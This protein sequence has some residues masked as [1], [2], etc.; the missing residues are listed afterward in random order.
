MYK[1]IYSPTEE[2]AVNSRSSTYNEEEY[3]D[4]AIEF[5]KSLN[6]TQQGHAFTEE[7]C[8]AELEG[9]KDDDVKLVGYTVLTP[10]TTSDTVF[11]TYLGKTYYYRLSSISTHERGRDGEPIRSQPEDVILDWTLGILNVVMALPKLGNPAIAIPYAG[12]CNFLGHENGID[13][14]DQAYFEYLGIYSLT[15]R[16]IYTYRGSVEKVVYMDQTGISDCSVWYHPVDTSYLPEDSQQPYATAND[17]PMSSLFYDDE[18]TIL[19][20]CNTMNNHNTTRDMRI[21]NIDPYEYWE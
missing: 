9:F 17:V 14:N 16:N 20:V 6:L 1:H 4:G 13:I 7:L 12:I 3:I 5:V 18:D 11:G 2:V 19:Q 21:H 8:L 15:T 10:R